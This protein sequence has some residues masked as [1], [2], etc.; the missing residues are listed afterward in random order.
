MSVRTS[1]SVIPSFL[2]AC[3]L[4]LFAAMMN[5]QVNPPQQKTTLIAPAALAKLLPAF[6]GWTKGEARSSQIDLTSECCYTFASAPYTKDEFRLKLTI[7]DTGSREE[8]LLAL[9]SM[10]VTLPEDC[11]EMWDSG[12]MSGEITVVVAGRFVVAVEAQKADSLDTL[13]ALL[14]SVDLKAVG[15]LK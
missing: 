1:S 9:A 12:K 11:V 3:I 5:A 2:T 7:A 15:A 8:P 6:E 13:R 4:V 14:A 10:V